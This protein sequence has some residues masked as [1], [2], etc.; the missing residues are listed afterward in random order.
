M[1][2]SSLPFPHPPQDW[3]PAGAGVHTQGPGS[4]WEAR[5]PDSERLFSL[6]CESGPQ[7][8]HT[9]HTS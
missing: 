9:E 1:Q 3:V 5:T 6:R 2:S 4:P 7:S 8:A